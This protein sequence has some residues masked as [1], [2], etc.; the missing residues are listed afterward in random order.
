MSLR[1]WHLHSHCEEVVSSLLCVYIVYQNHQA[2]DIAYIHILWC[3]V[4]SCF[5][6]FVLLQR[7][8]CG[9]CMRSVKVSYSCVSATHPSSTY[10]SG[11]ICIVHLCYLGHCFASLI[12][13]HCV[14]W[15][16]QLIVWISQ[17]KSNIIQQLAWISQSKSCI[18]SEHCV[19]F[20]IPEGLY[21]MAVMRYAMITW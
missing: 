9:V 8:I 2:R 21:S 11:P 16:I 5:A 6:Y 10:R 4:D 7:R 12:Y 17:S 19:M 1:V 13:F 15:I 3:H 18:M 20:F 14:R